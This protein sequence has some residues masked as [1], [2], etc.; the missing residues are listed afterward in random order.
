MTFTF[1]R[2]TCNLDASGSARVFTL[3]PSLLHNPIRPAVERALARG[4]NGSHPAQAATDLIHSA[5]DLGH[6]VTD[7]LHSVADCVHSATD[8]SP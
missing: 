3:D 5:A 7:L 1:A 2:G 8:L 4:L 6:S